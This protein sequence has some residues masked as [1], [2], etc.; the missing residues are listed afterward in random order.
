VL[1]RRAFLIVFFAY[2]L[3]DLGCPLVPGAFSFD[4]AESV[5]AVNACRVRPA[6]LPRVASLP[7][8]VS[9]MLSPTETAARSG[10]EA[11]IGP[12]VPRRRHPGRDQLHATDL[13]PPTEDD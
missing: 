7:P 8:P 10:E 3:L 2:L 6:G 5:E 4:P 12:S 1:T 11:A 13:R 9:S